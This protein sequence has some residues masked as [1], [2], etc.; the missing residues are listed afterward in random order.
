MCILGQR[1]ACILKQILLPS[2][3]CTLISRAFAVVLLIKYQELSIYIYY[4]VD[5]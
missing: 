4:V 5:F 3:D 1:H 2:T